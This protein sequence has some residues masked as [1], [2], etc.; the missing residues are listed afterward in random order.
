MPFD[1]EIGEDHRRFH[2]LGAPQRG[3]SV[4]D[5]LTLPAMP[6]QNERDEPRDL[7]IV[8]HDQNHY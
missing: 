1:R 7:R 3:L 6:L 5:D 2:L 4:R 8:F